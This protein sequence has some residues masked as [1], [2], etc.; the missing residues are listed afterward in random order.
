M[1][2]RSI[3]LP[4][5]G[6][7]LLFSVFALS[8]FAGVRIAFAFN[9]GSQVTVGNAAPTVTNVVLN[10]GNSITLTANATTA[11]DISFTVTDD[12]G[13]GDVFFNGGAT[14]TAAR[15]G[16]GVPCTA[17]DLSCYITAVIATNTCPF[18]TSSQTSA[19]AT[20]TVYIYYFADA[21]D[22]SSSYAAQEWVAH[23]VARDQANTTSSATS[24]HRELL[25][26]N[27]VN[28]T[29]S[30]LNYGALSAGVNTGATNQTATTTN[31]GN[32]TTTLR[33]HASPT[34]TS[35]SNTIATS[36]QRYATSSFTFPGDA[37]Q[38]Q[39]A[40][41]TVTGYSLTNPTSTNS[42][43]RATFWGLEVPGGT[44]TGTYTGTNVFTSLYLP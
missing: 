36:S 30:T 29:T 40:A 13:C 24:T 8:V 38:L 17:S 37:T 9:V 32:S 1:T 33:L 18:A 26:L 31:A 11:I 23:V 15:T 16:V 43:Q 27:A 25:T 41:V 7:I 14:S 34:L 35:G 39:S 6:S 3:A 22:A 19:N 20:A 42:V 28:V 21:T 44:A 5:L 12:N 2:K 4:S 10:G